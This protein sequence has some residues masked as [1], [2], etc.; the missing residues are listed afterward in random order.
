MYIAQYFSRVKRLS[1]DMQL[2][3]W[4][5]GIYGFSIGIIG[6]LFNLHLLALGFHSGAIAFITSINPLAT[7]VL[8]VLMG[9]LADRFG[10]KRM[11][12]IGSTLLA[13][14]AVLQPLFSSFL[15]ICIASLIFSIGQAM[16]GAT[17]FAVVAAYVS[18]KERDFAIS[19]IFANFM[20][21]IGIGSLVGG[22]LPLWLPRIG[23][24]YE[25]TL[26]LG[27]IIFCI[28]PLARRKLS[29]VSIPQK[30][31]M[32]RKGFLRPSRPVLLFSVFA[33]LSGLSYGFAMPYLNLILA[34]QFGLTTT[35]I[36]FVIAINEFALFLGSFLS[37]MVLDRFSPQQ[38]LGPLLLGAFILNIGIV[39]HLPLLFFVFL[40]MFR[41][42]INMTYAPTIDSLALGVV[43]DAQRAIMQSYRGLTR[44]IGSILS[45]WIGGELLAFKQYGWEFAATGIVLLC[46]FIFY[47]I[48]LKSV[49]VRSGESIVE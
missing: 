34:G 24:P 18:D 29:E 23:T 16:V 37:P 4:T 15:L 28:T 6:V 5:D 30:T 33:F 44:G 2:F 32:V 17:E 11:L 14:G 41:S 31:H 25:S 36:G 49:V 20:M 10:R 35:T 27:G 43:M 46:M 8:S 21:M 45:V 7:T 40:L 39:F 22:W 42:M 9:G 38:I 12:V 19:V 47:E 3:L 13:F 48:A 26:L 1:P